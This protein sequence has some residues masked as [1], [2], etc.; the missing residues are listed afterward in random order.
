MTATMAGAFSVALA[1]LAPFALMA[2]IVGAP[3]ARAPHRLLPL[4]S[5]P[6]LGV[7]LLP[8]AVLELPQVMLGTRLA[9][10]EVGR[11]LLLLIGLAWSAAAWF[12][13]DRLEER[14]RSFAVFWLAALGGLVTTALAVDVATFYTGYVAMTLAGYGLVIHERTPQAQH[15]GRVYLILALVGEALLLSG[16]LLIGAKLG[17]AEL[18]SLSMALRG[19]DAALAGT[20]LLTGFSVK[21]GVVPLHVW[22]PLAHPVAPVPASAI[23]SGVLVKAGLLGAVRTVPEEAFGTPGPTTLLLAIG[24]VT[25]FYGVAMGLVQSRLKTVLAYSTISQMGL[26]F[27][28]LALSIGPGGDRG[29]ALLAVLV[30][31][32]GLNKAAL[33]LAAGSFPGASRLRLALLALPALSL[34]GL[35]LTTGELAKAALKN[36]LHEAPAGSWTVPLLSLSSFATALLMLRV[37]RLA[38]SLQ[39]H[40]ARPAPPVHPAW[41]LLVVLAATVPW[42]LAAADGIAKWPGLTGAWSSSWP[43]AAALAVTLAWAQWGRPGRCIR[44]PEGDVLVPAAAA[45]AAV[46]RTADSAARRV[47]MA[48]AAAAAAIKKHFT[49]AQATLARSIR[50]AETTMAA[51]P[52]AGVV[53]LSAAGLVWWALS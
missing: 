23:L 30:L 35:P 12:A 44:V 39:A 4:A 29:G 16:L 5:L 41:W 13:A 32:H 24:F 25:A 21:I 9:A 22:L 45:L 11:P 20:L 7:A 10:D 1:V 50:L 42:A 26:L 46:L 34:A 6:A 28:G 38:Q 53:I 36:A 43:A 52:L 51:L 33:F 18:A 14:R 49:G 3:S 27:C 31:H 40:H 37:W 19:S 2:W 47:G 48:T 17:N 8:E 15:A